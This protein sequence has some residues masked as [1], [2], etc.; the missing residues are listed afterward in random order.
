MLFVP[1]FIKILRTKS[2]KNVSFIT[3]FGFNIIQ[4]L[5]IA[6]AYLHN[7]YILLIGAALSLLT[8]GSVAGLIAMYKLKNH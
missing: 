3:F 7:D 8:C 1:Q 4:F 6:H 2:A 5:V